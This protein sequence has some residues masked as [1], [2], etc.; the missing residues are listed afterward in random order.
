ML[1]NVGMAFVCIC[2]LGLDVV[3]L[4]ITLYRDRNCWLR[5]SAMHLVAGGVLSLI[6]SMLS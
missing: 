3:S 2:T 1:L 5:Q 4:A 6:Y